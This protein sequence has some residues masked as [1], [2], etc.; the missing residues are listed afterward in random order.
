MELLTSDDSV[1]KTPLVSA[2]DA[3]SVP[4]SGRSPAI[5][6]GSPLPYSWEYWEI[7]WTEEPAGLQSMRSQRVGHDS[8]IKEQTN[9]CCTAFCVGIKPFQSGISFLDLISTKL[10]RIETTIRHCILCVVPE[11]AHPELFPLHMFCP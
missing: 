2:G 9:S 1:V 11:A 4:E 3:A 10:H 7:P 5:G 6:D 8:T